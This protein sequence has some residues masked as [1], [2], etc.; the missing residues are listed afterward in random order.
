MCALHV[1]QSINQITGPHQVSLCY[2]APYLRRQS[3]GIRMSESK[4]ALYTQRPSFCSRG[5]HAETCFWSSRGTRVVI[6]RGTFCPSSPPRSKI[7]RQTRT[8]S[9]DLP[10]RRSPG[11]PN[12]RFPGARPCCP[13]QIDQS[14]I[15]NP[16]TSAILFPAGNT[17]P[18]SRELTTSPHP[19]PPSLESHRRPLINTNPRPPT[20]TNPDLSPS[21]VP[22]PPAMARLTALPALLLV[23]FLLSAAPAAGVRCTQRN[24]TFASACF[25]HLVRIDAVRLDGGLV[26]AVVKGIFLN[27]CLDQ[28]GSN[29]EL[30][31]GCKRI[32]GT[33]RFSKRKS[34]RALD[35]LQ[36]NCGIPFPPS[37]FP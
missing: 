1:S 18:Q 9:A 11:T 3:S 15:T 33:K 29:A 35:R 24:I 7:S 5:A 26:G 31:N 30:R 6:Q 34:L 10:P 12:W 2:P 27:A 37:D 23:F 25:C 19:S 21:P 17:S 14:P 22:A 20:H 13:S 4:R 36:R 28:F 32:A 16:A 8:P